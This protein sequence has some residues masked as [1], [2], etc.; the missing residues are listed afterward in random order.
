[1][2]CRHGPEVAH[3]FGGGHGGGV[4]DPDEPA[5]GHHGDAVGDRQHFLQVG[6]DRKAQ[7]VMRRFMPSNTAARDSAG[8]T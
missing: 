4:A 3:Q 5:S 7:A 6:Q 2:S 8:T 1:M